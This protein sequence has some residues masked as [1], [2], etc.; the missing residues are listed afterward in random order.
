MELL[1]VVNLQVDGQDPFERIIRHICTWLSGPNV[2]IE[3]ADFASNGSCNLEPARAPDGRQDRYGEWEVITLPKMR[4]V[5]L[6]VAQHVSS[7]LDVKTR[8]T[9]TEIDGITN[10]R[11][12][13][14]R[15]TSKQLMAPMK[16]TAVYQPGILRLLDTDETLDLK[17]KQQT[18]ERRYIQVKTV[19]EA[20]TVTSI[21]P[22]SERLPIAIIHVRTPETWD[23][24]K[25]LASKLLGLVR[26]IT[27]NHHTAQIIGEH[28][29]RAMVP[30]AGLAIVW[31]GLHSDPLTFSANRIAILG[32][33]QVR[34]TL[35]LTIGAL[36]AL[37]NG[38]DV[39][40]KTVRNAA[41]RARM[42][43][44]STRVEHA[45]QSG[46]T[47]EQISA[48][49]EQIEALEI[50]KNDAEQVGEDAL[51]QADNHG[52]RAKKLESELSAARDETEMWKSSYLKIAGSSSEESA[53]E[54]LDLWDKI[55]PLE[56]AKDPSEAFL[57][58]SDAASGSLIFTDRAHRSWQDIQYPDPD[59]MTS[60]LVSLARASVAL[61]E[62]K[63]GDFPHLDTWM[64][65]QFGLTIALTDQTISKWKRKE[66]RWLNDFEFEGRHLNA[67]PHVKVRDAVKFNECGRIHFALD[68]E[69][70][71]LVVQHVGIKTYK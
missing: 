53:P 1:Y 50:A 27:V 25:E 48:L 43:E 54:T 60:K 58:I 38:E 5:K 2:K 65:E 29:P 26:T 69:N 46:D 18:V 6:T 14:S 9:V 22:S 24:A 41:E 39:G 35:A 71:R 36:A 56:T 21:L 42:A 62:Q 63:G 8:V 66:M 49:K 51:E 13:I 19:A 10:F 30:F 44:L 32:P 57:S 15:E 45:R 17:Y 47:K 67:T 20:N 55:K 7:I 23:L 34:E 59:D 4:G 16:R 31:P 40:W 28:D 3:P 37:S 11:V 64:K 33:D 68:S 52:L 70:S 12:G 61:Y